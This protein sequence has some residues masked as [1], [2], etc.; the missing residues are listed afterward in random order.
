MTRAVRCA[1][2]LLE[3]RCTREASTG[4]LPIGA[5]MGRGGAT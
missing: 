5:L 2:A 1:Q 4:L 3:D